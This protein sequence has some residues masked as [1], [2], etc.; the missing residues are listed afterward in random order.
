MKRGGEWLYITIPEK[1]E[2][3]TVEKVMKQKW[4]FPRKLR[5]DFRSN[6]KVLL[7]DEHPHWKTTKV[8]AGDVLRLKL[9]QKSDFQLPTFNMELDVL[10][11]DDHLL[12]VNK[13]AGIFTHPNGA[14]DDQHTLWNAVAHYCRERHLPVLPKYIHRLDRHTSG[15]VLFGKHELA[16]ATLGEMMKK[17]QITRTY[18]AKVHG[19]IEHE[20]GRIEYPIIKDPT[21][22][23]K[24]KIDGEGPS[25]V[26]NYY[27]LNR[28]ADHTLLR[29][30]LET[31][32]TH[33]I[34]VHLH[35]I[36]HPLLGDSLYG[37]SGDHLGRQA[38]HAA[39]LSF[40]HPF[41]EERITCSASSE[42]SPFFD[43]NDLE[44]L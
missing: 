13:P 42:T 16:I 1:W 11:E 43:E 7:N 5:H 3:L 21:H 9:F 36:G 10:F 40:P 15:A 2:G 24:R 20:Q 34:R 12:V 25:S 14:E 8:H 22:P 30:H 27:V 17:R 18:I 29:L 33:Q 41:T 31:G 39:S 23:I 26:T 28:E 35:A 37:G 44:R 6:G 4:Q 19:R 38:L 32:R